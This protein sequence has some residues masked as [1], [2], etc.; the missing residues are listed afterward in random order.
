ML[1]DTLY[2]L[3]GSPT[4]RLY[5]VDT[6]DAS[7]NGSWPDAI[8][9]DGCHCCFDWSWRQACSYAAPME[10]IRATCGLLI[11]ADLPRSRSNIGPFTFQVAGLGTRK[12]DSADF[13]LP[14]ITL[15]DANLTAI[16]KA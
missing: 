8:R 9:V 5:E 10:P 14:N 16:I 6:D 2:G 13:L 11:L 1:G 4:T 12:L 7:C 3:L 15:S